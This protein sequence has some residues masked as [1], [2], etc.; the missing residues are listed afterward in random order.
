[1][2]RPSGALFVC[3]FA[4]G[5]SNPR[6]KGAKMAQRASS[7]TWRQETSLVGVGTEQA[8]VVSERLRPSGARGFP[9]CREPARKAMLIFLSATA[10]EE[11]ADG[12]E[13]GEKRRG[14]GGDAHPF[15]AGEL[16]QAR[17]M[18]SSCFPPF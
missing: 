14:I 9:A 7:A 8:R 6:P 10:Q 5:L 12:E 18:W 2:A 4:I 3:C 13:D 15:F 1:M 16:L 11:E 17:G